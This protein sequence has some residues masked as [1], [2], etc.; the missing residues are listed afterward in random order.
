MFH[1]VV[2]FPYHVTEYSQVVIVEKSLDDLLTKNNG[3]CRDKKKK[4]MKRKYK[5]A[6]CMKIWPVVKIDD[7]DVAIELFST[8]ENAIHLLYNSETKSYEKLEELSHMTVPIWCNSRINFEYRLKKQPRRNQRGFH[9]TDFCTKSPAISSEVDSSL[10]HLG[11]Q[12]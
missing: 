7:R 2:R 5:M 1:E 3:Y 11:I 9:R 8:K 10:W 6:S 12:N 4:Y